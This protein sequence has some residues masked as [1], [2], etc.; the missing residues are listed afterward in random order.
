[1]GEIERDANGDG[2]NGVPDPVR[3]RHDWSTTAP[4]IAIIEAIASVEDVDPVALTAGEESTLRE[5][6][7]PEL[8]DRLVTNARQDRISITITVDSYTVRIEGTELIVEPIE[9]DPDGG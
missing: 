2:G 1:M 5:Y 9:D 4:S 7:D 3:A 6:V 8:L